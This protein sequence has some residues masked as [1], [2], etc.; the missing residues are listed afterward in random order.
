MT[1][2]VRLLLA[3]SGILLFAVGLLVGQQVQRSTFDKYLRTTAT[4]MD[5]ALL[6]ADISTI[7]YSVS[8]APTINYVPACACFEAR[9][10]MPSELSGESIANVKVGLFN[11]AMLTRN[12]VQA[13]VPEMSKV[14]TGSDRDF[15]M[16]FW[17]LH[18]DAQGLV[19]R[20][21]EVAEYSGGE[22]VIK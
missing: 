2:T 9:A 11:F 20:T 7:R 1:Q 19:D 14:G 5:V 10:M 6:R 22:I 18:K 21:Q 17:D 15:R 13:E 12:A 4:L 8:R 16:T 3:L